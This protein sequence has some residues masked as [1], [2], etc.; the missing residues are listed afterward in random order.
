MMFFDATARPAR[1][2]K[3][4]SGNELES[5]ASYPL[6]RS[7][8]W[9]EQTSARYVTYREARG[10]RAHHFHHITN[11]L[12]SPLVSLISTLGCVVVIRA[13]KVELPTSSSIESR[14][15]C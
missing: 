3:R 4:W 6:F 15:N 8:L 7:R 11:R 10:T 9:N 5:G 14:Y 1:Y 2:E 12:S 13:N